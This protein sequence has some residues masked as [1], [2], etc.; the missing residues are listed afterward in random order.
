MLARIVELYQQTY[1]RTPTANAASWLLTLLWHENAGGKAINNYNW[2][3]L[4]AN[5]S[6]T[7]PVW[8]HPSP[9]E[10]EP[11]G[12]RV[13][14]SHEAGSLAWWNV[15]H[16]SDGTHL[17]IVRAAEQGNAKA[18]FDA[19]SKPHPKTGKAYCTSCN[20]DAVKGPAFRMY[21]AI[22]DQILRAG[23]VRGLPIGRR[24]SSSGGGAGVLFLALSILGALAA[25][26]GK[27]W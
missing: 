19:V 27:S 16:Q 14:P 11:T 8:E 24:A 15:L 6:W 5:S 17:R 21:R 13:Y 9:T 10:G 22:H 7:G 26:K 18:F 1:G 25:Y 3:N 20:K 12:F 4:A 23:L 2:G